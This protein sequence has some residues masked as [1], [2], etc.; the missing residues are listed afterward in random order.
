M[1]NPVSNG[2]VVNESPWHEGEKTL[3]AS[4]GMAARMETI[5]RRVLRPFMTDQHRDFFNQLPFVVAGVVDKDGAPWATFLADSPG[6][7]HSPEPKLLQIRHRPPKDDP[8]SAGFGEGAGI[9]LLGIELHTRRRNRV[10]GSMSDLTGQGFS[11]QVEQTMGNCPKY[12]ALRHYRKASRSELEH[13]PSIEVA[14]S[15]G[16]GD[17]ATIAA[18]DSFFVASYMDKAGHRQVDASHR[19]GKPGFIRVGSEG[20]LTIPDF[21]GNLF[22][23]TLGNILVNGKAGVVIADFEQGDVLQMT[24]RAEVILDSPEIVAFEGA[25]RLWTFKPTR[26]VRRRGALPIRWTFEALSPYVNRL[27]SWEQVETNLKNGG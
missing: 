22:F 7:M 3:Q 11:I 21:S 8:A 10:N 4:V 1:D 17:V 5:G 24:G 18:A 25:E 12:I 20:V 16:P 6:F 9:G 13:A 14:T 26:V 19:G 23:N 15:L 2:H 27:G